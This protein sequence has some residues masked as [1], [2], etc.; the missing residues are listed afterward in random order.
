MAFLR[1]LKIVS[2]GTAALYVRVSTVGPSLTKIMPMVNGHACVMRMAEHQMCPM[3][4]GEHLLAWQDAFRAVF[5]RSTTLLSISLTVKMLLFG[6]ADLRNTAWLQNQARMPSGPPGI[7]SL[8]S[9][10]VTAGAHQRLTYG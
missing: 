8:F 4:A 2:L 9:F 7:H 1:I 10:L 5:Q 6:S 3:P